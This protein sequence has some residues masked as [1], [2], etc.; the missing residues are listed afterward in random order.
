MKHDRILLLHLQQSADG[1]TVIAAA[2]ADVPAVCSGVLLQRG[3]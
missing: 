1:N 2:Q 3:A